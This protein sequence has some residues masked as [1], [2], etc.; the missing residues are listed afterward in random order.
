MDWIVVAILI[1]IFLYTFI[2]DQDSDS[3]IQSHLSENGGKSL[4]D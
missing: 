2:P 1:L 3:S 4:K